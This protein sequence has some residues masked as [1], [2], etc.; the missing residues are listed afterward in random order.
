M[1]KCI[2][3]FANERGNYIHGISRLAESLRTNFDGDFLPFINESSL[4]CPLHSENPYAFKI[5]AFQ[6]AIDLGYDQILWLDSSCFAVGNLQPVFDEITNDGFIFQEAGHLVGTWTSD[7][8]LNYWSITR[9]AAMIMPMIGNAGFLGLRIHSTIGN[10]FFK[11][12][13]LSMEAGCFKG[14][15]TN[16][17][18]TESQDPRCRGSRHDM[19][20]SSIIANLMGI[21]DKAKKGNEWLQ[22]AGIYDKTLNDTIL[23]KAQGL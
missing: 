19:V 18:L 22:Y 16:D 2:I 13:K 17:N 11:R 1:K 3:S 10:E 20:N 15:W 8:V 21:I 5:Y 14:A 6:K 4:G 7:F 12:W 23:I 9:D